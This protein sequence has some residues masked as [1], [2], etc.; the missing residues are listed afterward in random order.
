MAFIGPMM[1]Q[2]SYDEQIQPLSSHTK[3]P[4]RIQG[5]EK[6]GIFDGTVTLTVGV[7]GLARYDESEYIILDE[8]TEIQEG[9]GEEVQK[10]KIK[11]LDLRQKRR[12]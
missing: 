5:L 1:T 3:L 4:P 2:Y 6:L 8:F 10:Y 12:T 11:E 9:T 7:N